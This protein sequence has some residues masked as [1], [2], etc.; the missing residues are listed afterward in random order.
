[1]D[2]RELHDLLISKGVNRDAFDVLGDDLQPIPGD[3]YVLRLFRSGVV[4][5]P[6]RWATYYSERGGMNNLRE[7]ATEDEACRSF[8]SMMDKDLSTLD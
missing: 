6:S 8:L 3:L 7:F 4:G 5:R 1:M 2:R